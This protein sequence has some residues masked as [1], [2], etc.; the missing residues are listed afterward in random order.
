MKKSNMYS[1][2]VFFIIIISLLL[3]DLIIYTGLL[4]LFFEEKETMWAGIIGFTGAVIG[5]GITY[6]GIRMQLNH[7]DRELFLQTVHI[8]METCQEFIRKYFNYQTLAYGGLEISRNL[9]NEKREKFLSNQSYLIPE[10]TELIFQDRAA[11]MSVL[12]YESAE[13]AKEI[14]T[15]LNKKVTTLGKVKKHINYVEA[16][17][18]I[19]QYCLIFH[20]TFEQLENKYIELKKFNK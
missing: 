7:R 17:E 9:D 20:K 15:S 1:N 6:Y 8:K 18:E 16:F 19:E 10:F 5:G 13:K 2:T 12:D 11:Y 4:N 3:G 14:R